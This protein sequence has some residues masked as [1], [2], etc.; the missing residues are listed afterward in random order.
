MSDPMRLSLCFSLRKRCDLF[1]LPM[2]KKYRS[3]FEVIASILES[4]QYGG[5]TSTSIMKLVNTNHKQ[6]TKYLESLVQMGFIEIGLENSKVLYRSGEKGFEFLRHYYALKE[7][8]LVRAS[9]KLDDTVQANS[10]ILSNKQQHP[11]CFTR[12]S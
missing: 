10:H 8:L 3:H 9:R 5:A 7:M 1:G 2:N 4:T 11:S 12:G 6:I